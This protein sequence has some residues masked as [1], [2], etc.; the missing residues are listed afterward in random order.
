MSRSQVISDKPFI[1]CAYELGVKQN[2]VY[3]LYKMALF[4]KVGKFGILFHL[5]WDNGTL[6]SK[7]GHLVTQI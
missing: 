6:H 4:E 1:S 3:L 7:M 2:F 5:C